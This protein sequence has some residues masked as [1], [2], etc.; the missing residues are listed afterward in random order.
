[1]GKLYEEIHMRPCRDCITGMKCYVIHCIFRMT[2]DDEFAII[3]IW[4]MH[5]Y[6][7][8][9]DQSTVGT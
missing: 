4:Y 2:H 6:A 5:K 3:F 8:G 9:R 1:M 7:G